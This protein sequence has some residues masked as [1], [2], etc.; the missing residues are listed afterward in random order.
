MV[1]YDKESAVVAE[2]RIEL[3]SLETEAD[4]ETPLFVDVVRATMTLLL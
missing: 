4:D 2:A 3:D 1:L